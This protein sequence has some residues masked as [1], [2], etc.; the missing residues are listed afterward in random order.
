MID[1]NYQGKG[2]GKQSVDKI[3]S[4]IKTMPY[5]KADYLYLS[6]EPENIVCKKLFTSFGFE[7][8]GKKLGDGDEIIARLKI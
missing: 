5:G 3:I 8:T 2:Y 7:D 6:Y 1:K 4:E